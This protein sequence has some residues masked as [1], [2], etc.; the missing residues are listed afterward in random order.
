MF[1][2]FSETRKP[3]KR[4]LISFFRSRENGAKFENIRANLSYYSIRDCARWRGDREYSLNLLAPLSALQLFSTVIKQ[5]ASISPSGGENSRP[6]NLKQIPRQYLRAVCARA[7][8]FLPDENRQARERERANVFQPCNRTYHLSIL[9][10]FDDD[11]ITATEAPPA[12]A[13]PLNTANFTGIKRFALCLRFSLS[14]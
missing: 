2:H 11:V 1:E 13:T 4:F 8:P 14:I 10:L 9:C 6:S 5:M 3:D 7:S 12:E